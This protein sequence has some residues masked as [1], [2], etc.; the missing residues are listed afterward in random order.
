MA[1]KYSKDCPQF[2]SCAVR[3]GVVMLGELPPRN[4]DDLKVIGCMAS[5]AARDLASQL[6]LASD[7]ADER[8]PATSDH[9]QQ[10][11]PKLTAQA[12]HAPIQQVDFMAMRNTLVLAAFAAEARRVLTDIQFV[13]SAI[14]EMDEKLSQLVE[15][16]SQWAVYDDTLPEVLDGIA[17]QL[18][19]LAG[20]GQ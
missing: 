5:A 18:A 14:P 13:T 20:D 4:G 15:A 7:V 1:E 16:R 9:P 3:D 11:V 6:L 17:Q 12:P 10:E 2:T 8:P 19:A